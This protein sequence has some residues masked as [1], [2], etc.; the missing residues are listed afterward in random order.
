MA[1]SWEPFGST[2]SDDPAPE[3]A[4]EEPAPAP[5]PPR[6]LS[7][8]PAHRLAVLT[9]MDCRIDPLAA[10]G[11]RLGD[12]VVLRNAGAQASD[13]MLRSLRMAHDALGV[14]EVEVVAHTDCAAHGG[15]DVA[16][17]AAARQAAARISAAVAGVR[18]TPALLDLASG[19][20]SRP[21]AA[22]PPSG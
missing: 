10:L 12:A 17:A 20:V 6:A 4:R 21:A 3:P 22:R 13:D 8:R 14:R 11:L 16:A 7:N 5:P 9:C 19:A 15:D 1:F 2:R 18:A